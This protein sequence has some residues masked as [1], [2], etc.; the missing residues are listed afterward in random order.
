MA[1]EA[2]LITGACGGIGQAL[3][4][5]FRNAGYFVI[6][7]DRSSV[8]STQD[9]HLVADLRLIARS[10]APGLAFRDAVMRSL[11]GRV[12][13]CLVNNA[14]LQKLGHIGSIAL[15]DIHDTIDVNVVAPL[16]LGQLFVE[17]LRKA[18]G[19][20][21]NIG[22]I[23]SD[24]TKPGFVSYSTSKAALAGLTRAMA[25]DLGGGVRVNTI[26]PA[27]I[28]TEML[29]EGFQ[30]NSQAWDELGHHHPAGR[31]GQPEEVAAMAVFLA[32]TQAVNACQVT[33]RQRIFRKH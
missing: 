4:T 11:D 23:H 26:Q 21:I 15:D 24:L 14:A 16:V 6:S 13:S 22:S 31:I 8:D 25:V 32:S 20:I 33:I 1:D 2:V 5:A 12:L 9:H 17:D 19:S 30:D 27:A 18:R 29:R 7:T 28:S 3:C 10:S